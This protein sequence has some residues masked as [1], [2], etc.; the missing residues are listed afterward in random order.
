VCAV[1]IERISHLSKLYF[2]ILRSTCLLQIVRFGVVYC[3]TETC[4]WRQPCS[5]T[6]WEFG[7]PHTNGWRTVLH[8]FQKSSAQR[9]QTRKH[10][11]FDF[12][13]QG[14][15]KNF[16]LWAEQTDQRARNSFFNRRN[17]RSAQLHVAGKSGTFE[18]NKGE[19]QKVRGS[20]SSD[21]FSMGC[22]FYHFVSKGNHPFGC[23]HDIPVNVSKGKYQFVGTE[24]PWRVNETLEVTNVRWCGSGWPRSSDCRHGRSSNPR[25]WLPLLSD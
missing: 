8:S 23:N 18:K 12:Q 14:S 10:S 6:S 19:L 9:Y 25:P 11:R 5:V 16:R 21:V 4:H 20:T 13:Y 22:V 2:M 24:E 3:I 7:R 15:V 17:Q 1:L